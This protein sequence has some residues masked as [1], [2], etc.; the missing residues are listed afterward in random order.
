MNKNKKSL[1][2]TLRRMTR[3]ATQRQKGWTLLEA[4]LTCALL[5]LMSVIVYNTIRV[6]QEKSSVADEKEFL[7]RAEAAMA[8][9]VR[10]GKF[11]LLV[12]DGATASPH[13][14]GYVEGW[15]PSRSLGLPPSR[16][17][18]YLVHESLVKD[19]SDIYKPDPLQLADGHIMAREPAQIN[20]LDFC[21]VLM[22]NEMTGTALPDG[23]R[24]A[25]ALQEVTTTNHLGG[26]L[27]QIW[28]ADGAAGTAPANVELSTLTAGFAEYSEWLG[29]RDKFARLAVGTKATVVQNELVKLAVQQVDYR[30]QA[31]TI[32]R[33]F[34]DNLDWTFANF[35]GLYL[36][37][38][39]LDVQINLVQM[40]L[41]KSGKVE[42]PKTLGV[43][44]AEAV[45]IAAAVGYFGYKISSANVTVEAADKSAALADSYRKEVESLRDA[46]A[47]QTN[48]DQIAGLNP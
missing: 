12:P 46:T 6:M 29:C 15:L 43:S 34:R 28:L 30:L 26:A 44:I 39:I 21:L 8:G 20:G 16:R 31:A 40:K 23:M 25:F 11:T 2:N 45:A 5:G 22:R 1:M 42:G 32:A 41:S 10:Q 18:R 33:D 38:T 3:H 27:N 9:W 19:L 17:V 14:P 47:A 35:F 13:R 37:Q 24:M 48:R 36:P 7:P 4:A